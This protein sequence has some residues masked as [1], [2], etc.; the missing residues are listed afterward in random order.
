MKLL[1]IANKYVNYKLRQNGQ[2]KLNKQIK[3]A[4]N[5][6]DESIMK[7]GFLTNKGKYNKGDLL[8]LQI[9]LT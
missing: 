5:A 2:Y 4:N 9:Q 6:G 8:S 3:M 7:I 1:K